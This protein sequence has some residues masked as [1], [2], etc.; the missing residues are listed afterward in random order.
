M[1]LQKATRYALVA[2]VE[3]ASTP[4]RPLSAA[5]IAGKYGLSV[6]HMAKVLPVLAR[7]GLLKA[8]RG[9]AGGYRLAADPARLSLWDIVR[10]I[11]PP[12][13]ADDPAPGAL[14]AILA[15]AEVLGGI[16]STARRALTALTVADMVGRVRLRA[17]APGPNPA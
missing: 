14:P 13:P 2:V 3:M 11:E 1:K 12:D 17:K 6:N 10:V 5:E 16:E 7:A 4:A 8:L 15:M 9:A